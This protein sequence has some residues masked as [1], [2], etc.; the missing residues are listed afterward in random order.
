MKQEPRI[1]AVRGI[2]RINGSM[3]ERAWRNGPWPSAVHAPLPPFRLP[4]VVR[5]GQ[6]LGNPP[7]ALEGA[8][9][10]GIRVSPL[11]L[12]NHLVG[13]DAVD[14]QTCLR[15]FGPSLSGGFGLG[16]HKFVR[17]NARRSSIA[18]ACLPIAMSLLPAV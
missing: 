12:A 16:I 18:M 11:S 1:V 15:S 6:V 5:L 14:Q 17:K 13:F 2:T 10:D 8:V 7:G 9:D 3:N 4:I